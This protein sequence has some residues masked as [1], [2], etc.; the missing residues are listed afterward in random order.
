MKRQQRRFQQH[1]EKHH[2]VVKAVSE[3]G[4]VCEDCQT[5]L[6]KTHHYLLFGNR[7]RACWLRSRSGEEDM[8]SH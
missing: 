2:L 6:H 5:S 4:G 7:C 8:A 1:Q 3:R